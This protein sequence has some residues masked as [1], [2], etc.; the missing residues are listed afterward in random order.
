MDT[1]LAIGLLV[2]ASLLVGLAGA[3]LVAFLD[4]VERRIH[5]HARARPSSWRNGGHGTLSHG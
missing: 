2:G 3:V 4:Y 5:T 1:V